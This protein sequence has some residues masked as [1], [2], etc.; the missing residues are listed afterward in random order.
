MINFQELKSRL[1]N[2]Q[3]LLNTQ[4][5]LQTFYFGFQLS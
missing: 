5:L 4:I 1:K 2:E 3:G